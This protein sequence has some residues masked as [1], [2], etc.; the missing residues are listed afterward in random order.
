[1]NRSD[2]K[3]IFLVTGI[4]FTIGLFVSFILSFLLKGEMDFIWKLRLNLF[5]SGIVLV[6]LAMFFNVSN[7][8]LS[9]KNR[10][11][12]GEFEAEVKK[13]NKNNYKEL[14][15]ETKIGKIIYKRDI[16]DLFYKV[17]LAAGGAIFLLSFILSII[18][19]S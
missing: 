6:I 15:L 5:I 1:M 9:I 17:F 14:D 16:F 8:Y 11:A 10:K 13:D 19:I 12:I 4:V 2:K 3:F 18:K 7:I